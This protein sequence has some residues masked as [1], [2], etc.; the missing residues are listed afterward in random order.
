MR[1]STM[2]ELPQELEALNKDGKYD[3]IIAEAKAGEYHDYKN[4]KYTCGKVAVVE[5]LNEFPELNHIR[6]AVINGDYDESPD[7]DDK[8]MMRKDLGDNPELAKLLGL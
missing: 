1:K 8:E 4:Q 3:E 6:N 7:E 5:K 2:I